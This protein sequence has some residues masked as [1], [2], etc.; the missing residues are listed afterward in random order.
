M[1]SITT[2]WQF[3][4]TNHYTVGCLLVSLLSLNASPPGQ[5]GRHFA[6]EIFRCISVNETFCILIRISLTF[7]AKG[8]IDN[9][10]ALVRFMVYSHAISQSLKLYVKYNLLLDSL[11]TD[12]TELI[13]TL[14]PMLRI[15]SA[16]LQRVSISS[17][18]HLKYIMRA[19]NMNI[20]MY[21][22]TDHCQ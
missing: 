6:D 14:S 15:F 22:K 18:N 11:I 16:Q 17:C 21:F 3:S 4:Y 20:I 1:A 8:L 5:N 2:G 7:V 10:S 12:T 13:C 9:M 19:K